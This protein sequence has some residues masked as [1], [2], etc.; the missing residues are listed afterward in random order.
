MPPSR[1]MYCSCSS[2]TGCALTSCGFLAACSRIDCIL[3]THC[4]HSPRATRTTESALRSRSAKMRVSSRL[5]PTEPRS[6]ARS[7]KR[8]SEASD[9]GTCSRM[10]EIRSA[11]G[12]TTTIAVAVAA[13]RLLAQLVRD[14][15]ALQGR[16]A[17]PR[18]GDVEM[19]AVQEVRREADLARHVSGGVTDHGALSE[20]VARGQQQLDGRTLQR[21]RL[22]RGSGRMPE[23]GHARGVH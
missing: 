21:V 22:V 20:R 9:S 7:I 4:S 18:A 16:F 11:C 1:M 8:T 6:S 3:G 15:V 14:D 13:G 12:S 5:M 19:V 2:V 23:P 10:S 17:R